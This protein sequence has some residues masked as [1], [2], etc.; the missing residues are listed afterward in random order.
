MS[1]IE[2][3][4][5]LIVAAANDLD[6]DVR[7]NYSG[8]GMYGRKCVGITGGSSDLNS[9]L[10]EVA[11][12]LAPLTSEGYDGNQRLREDLETLFNYSQDS[13][14]LD[15]IFYWPALSLQEQG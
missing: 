2:S 15:R 13:M 10:A 3:L 11:Y 5:A 9:V 1:K 4:A 8:R 6:V 14:G 12:N 7:A